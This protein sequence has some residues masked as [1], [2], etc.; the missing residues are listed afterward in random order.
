[1]VR[2]LYTSTDLQPSSISATRL[3]LRKWHDELPRH[4]QISKLLDPNLTAKTRFGLYFAHLFYLSAMMLLLRRVLSRC[5]GPE[6]AALTLSN[7]ASQE[8][9]E[10]VNDGFSAARIAAR[11]LNQL[12]A[13]E[14]V[15]Q[16]CWHSM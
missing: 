6:E 2:E 7:H 9:F 11:I 10:A 1:M 5:K 15:F 13:E 16:R 12:L 4:M 8:L 3:D 14:A